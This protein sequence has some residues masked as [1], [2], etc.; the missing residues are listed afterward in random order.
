MPAMTSTAS[1]PSPLEAGLSLALNAV[2]SLD[3]EASA[4]VARLEGHRVR[5]VLKKPELQLEVCMREGKAE[6]RFPSE[7]AQATAA[8]LEIKT[9]PAALLKLLVQGEA[10]IGQLRIEGDAELARWVSE[11]LQNFRPDV[12]ELFS[13]GFGD[14]LGF[15]L[16]RVARGGAAWLRDSARRVAEQGVGYLRD[17]SRDVVSGSELS[18]FLDEI[19]DLRDRVERAEYRL[20]R[21]LVN[22]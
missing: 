14:V 22:T 19:D 1:T 15:Q 13:R 4:R 2:M 11:A 18:Q 6:L 16:A 20:Q 3:P 10:G 17:E 12:D 9:T 5:L 8:D 7:L 21:I